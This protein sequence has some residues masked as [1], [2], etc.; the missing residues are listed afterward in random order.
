MDCASDIAVAV[1]KPFA[2]KELPLEAFE[3]C[4]GSWRRQEQHLHARLIRFPVH[5]RGVTR[6]SPKEP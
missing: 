5:S 1:L 2:S 3:P 6:R 4:G